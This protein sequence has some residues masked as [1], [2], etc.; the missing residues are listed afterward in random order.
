MP[1]P[2]K[3]ANAVQGH[4]T[5][6]EIDTRKAAEE[7]LK[8]GAT[9]TER[10]E[11]K[12]NKYTH[13]EF[14]RVKKLLTII[15]KNDDLY[16]AIINRYCAIQ[17]EC[18]QFE[19]LKNEYN[20]AIIELSEDKEKIVED[21]VNEY[22]KETISLAQYYKMKNNFSRTII[23]LDSAVMSKRKMLFDIEKENLMTV[24][25]GLRSIPKTPPQKEEDP[26]LK[27]LSESDD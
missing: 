6:A 1:R 15:E 3:T 27:A 7:N 19:N 4:R 22:D 8:T 24:A 23:A 20:K 10:S 11:I 26:L 18:V 21:Y 25:S 14:L 13:K 12:I 5:K 16:S 9:L 17:F 2:S